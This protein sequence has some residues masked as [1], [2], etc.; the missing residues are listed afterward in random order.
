MVRYK[1]PFFLSKGVRCGASNVRSKN[2]RHHS[3]SFRFILHS[4]CGGDSDTSSILVARKN[5]ATPVFFLARRSDQSLLQYLI[6]IGVLF[7]MSGLPS[8]DKFPYESYVKSTSTFEALHHSFHQTL[9]FSNRGRLL[10]PY[11]KRI[12]GTVGEE[13][14]DI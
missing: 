6:L 12:P 7:F 2:A 4:R 10:L 9:C 3:C 14:L 1:K 5:T 13:M 11:T 8:V